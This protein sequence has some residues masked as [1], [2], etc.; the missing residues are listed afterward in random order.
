MLFTMALRCTGA[1]SLAEAEHPERKYRQRKIT[2]CLLARVPR[3]L[4]SQRR[5]FQPLHIVPDMR[6]IR[7]LWQQEVTDKALASLDKTTT[8]TT[9]ALPTIP[10]ANCLRARETSDRRI[11]AKRQNGP[12]TSL[13]TPWQTLS[14]NRVGE[15][16]GLPLRGQ[17]SRK[18]SAQSHAH[19]QLSLEYPKTNGP[20]TTAC[21]RNLKHKARLV[22][23][24]ARRLA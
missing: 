22:E 12:T 9:N 11:H 3:L 19:I 4:A 6:R 1:V 2:P 14:G 24:L 15:T 13:R 5:V 18:N 17:N 10:R 16:K 23:R 21:A 7:R 20:P 8:S